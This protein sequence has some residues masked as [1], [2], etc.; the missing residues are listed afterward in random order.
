MQRNQKQN[1]ARQNEV[2]T[3]H[4]RPAGMLQNRKG[5]IILHVCSYRK[6]ILDSHAGTGTRVTD[7]RSND[8]SETEIQARYTLL[9]DRCG[10]T[11]F[12]TDRCSARFAAA[13]AAAAGSCHEVL[14][15]L[16]CC[17]LLLM[18]LT[19]CCWLLRLFIPF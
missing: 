19:G 6:Q 15:I 13:A 4:K 2:K 10:G 16:C 11:Q 8:T 12:E 3:K 17:W 18:L 14:S 9:H 1:C 7:R 5:R